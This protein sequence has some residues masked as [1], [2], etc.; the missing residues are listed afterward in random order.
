MFRILDG[1]QLLLFQQHHLLGLD[2]F[3]R[4][5]AGE[6]D[7]GGKRGA[8]EDEGMLSGLEAVVGKGL[9]EAASDVEDADFNLCAAREREGNG[10]AGVEGIGETGK[11]EG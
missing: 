9:Y 6:V 5:Q 1:C 2:R 4:V 3:S 11:D 10:G 8:V 7:S